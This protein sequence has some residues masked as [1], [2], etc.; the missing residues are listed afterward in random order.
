MM[1]LAFFRAFENRSN[2]Q[3]FRE[4]LPWKMHEKLLMVVYIG[5]RD[6]LRGLKQKR[7]AHVA[8]F[9]DLMDEYFPDASLRRSRRE[10]EVH[11]LAL[12]RDDAFIQHSEAI[13]DI[14]ELDPQAQEII[15]H[16]E[17]RRVS[18]VA[19]TLSELY[20]EWRQ[21]V[22]IGM[23]NVLPLQKGSRSVRMVPD[24]DPRGVNNALGP[25]QR[26]IIRQFVLGNLV[27]VRFFVHEYSTSIV[28][29]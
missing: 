19:W 8:V 5:A 27:M 22:R 29:L 1:P 17:A 20:E 9:P 11:L 25:S 24:E 28:R 16:S 26:E 12:Q 23:D 6:L 3:L 10:L 7:P 4:S 13:R 2:G 21:L 15:N 18:K 14:I